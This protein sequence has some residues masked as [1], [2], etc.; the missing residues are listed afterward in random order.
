MGSRPLGHAFV[1][2]LEC[3]PQLQGTPP[4]PQLWATHDEV[5]I[6]TSGPNPA[7]GVGGVG[8]SD[9]AE[10]DDDDGGMPGLARSDSGSDGG[11]DHQPGAALPRNCSHRIQ[12]HD[13]APFR[14]VKALLAAGRLRGFRQ[15]AEAA[16]TRHHE[17][18]G[19][20]G[21]AN[22]GLAWGV[23]A[24]LGR[25]CVSTTYP[26]EE[27]WFSSD[28]PLASEMYRAHVEGQQVVLARDSPVLGHVQSRSSNRDYI[29]HRLTYEGEA[30]GWAKAECLAVVEVVEKEVLTL[31]G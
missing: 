14:P 26:V 13:A 20:R 16:A 28:W 27:D 22:L 30:R 19:S 8:G 5:P 2:H 21:P 6:T 1:Q 29:R 10:S 4:P 9:D 15:Q 23:G 3:W 7:G 25:H 11:G 18:A 17:A 24:V 12:P 31:T